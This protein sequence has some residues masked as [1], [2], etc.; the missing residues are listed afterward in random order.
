MK[1]EDIY[2]AINSLDMLDEAILILDN[3]GEIIHPDS[4]VLERVFTKSNYQLNLVTF[5]LKNLPYF[6]TVYRVNIIG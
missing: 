3:A 6:P 2:I 4:L 5:R 1:K